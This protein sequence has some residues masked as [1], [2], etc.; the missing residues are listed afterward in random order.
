MWWWSVLK[1]FAGAEGKRENQ[2]FLC[3]NICKEFSLAKPFKCDED[4]EVMLAEITEFHNT[5][6]QLPFYN[7]IPL[8]KAVNQQRKKKKKVYGLYKIHLSV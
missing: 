6:Y 1:C 8:G 7:T 4:N 2:Y 3:W 5:G